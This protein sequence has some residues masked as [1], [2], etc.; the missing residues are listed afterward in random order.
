M[1]FSGSLPPSHFESPE[2]PRSKF[3]RHVAAT[4][5]LALPV[6]LARS[7]TLIMISTDVIMTG[8]AGAIELAYYG[9]GFGLSQNLFVIG[10]GAMNGTTVLTSQ[11]MGLGRP[12]HCGTIW[13]VALAHALVMGLVFVALSLLGEGFLVLTGQ[14]AA[15]AAG[16]GY[17]M[18]MFSLGLPPVL[19]YLTTAMF[20]EAISRTLPNLVLMVGAN[21]LNVGLNW[22]FIYGGAFPAAG[23]I[24]GMGA[25]GAALATSLTRWA[26]FLGLVGYVY[27]MADQSHLGIRGPLRF[28]MDFGRKLRKLG[29]PLG[30]A[31][32]LETSAFT[33]IVLMAGVLGAI[34]LAAYQIASNLF[35][36]VYMSA[37]GL[38]TATSV[39][40]GIAVGEGRISEVRWCG[41][42]GVG[43]GAAV[44]MAFGAVFQVWPGGLAAL[45]TSDREAWALAAGVLPVV[46]LFLLPDGSQGILVGALRGT[47]DIWIPSAMVIVGFWGVA[48]PVGYLLAF[49][50]GLGI[51]GLIWGLALGALL[52]S[53]LLILR[54]HWRTLRPI[55]PV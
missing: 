4:L 51:L 36:V 23:G 14:E 26:M 8:R 19:M 55:E 54:F 15:L 18:W 50:Q 20:L 45:Y 17:T 47:G 35:I 33:S 48:V 10:L 42:S 1:P 39:R 7:G 21:L 27:W 2:A 25:A 3:L 31:H 11:A 52:A 44:L 34:P 37:I 22:I 13:R 16:G 30:L 38:A 43:V 53:V 32:G 12:E 41:W 6:M 5:K 28:A 40:V 49:P 29:L 24:F 9:L 46:G